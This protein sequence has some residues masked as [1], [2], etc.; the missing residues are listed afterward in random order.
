MNKYMCIIYIYICIQSYVI[1]GV[2]LARKIGTKTRRRRRSHA[3]DAHGVS[4]FVLPGMLGGMNTAGLPTWSR[5]IILSFQQVVNQK[6]M[7]ILA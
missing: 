1:R 2:H 3:F 4:L 5:K 6:P 7:E